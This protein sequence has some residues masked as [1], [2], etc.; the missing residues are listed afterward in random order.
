MGKILLINFQ[1][2]GNTIL[3]FPLLKALRRHNENDNIDMLVRDSVIQELLGP[4]NLV[5]HFFIYQRDVKGIK[6]F[7]S[8]ICVLQDLRRDLYDRIINFEQ[9]QT[10]KIMIF[11]AMM[12]AKEKI[13][14]N[15]HDKFFDP[16][17]RSITFSPQQQSESGLYRDIGK[18]LSCGDFHLPFPFF[19]PT[20]EEEERVTELIPDGSRTMI[21]I[22]PG[23]GE[24]LIYKRW[25]KERFAE[26][27]RRLVMERDASVLIFGGSTEV[28][29][30][31]YIVEKANTDHIYNMAGKFTVRETAAA[32]ARCSK[33]VSNDSGVMHLTAAMG[34][35]VIALFGPSSSIKNAPVGENHQ[36][37]CGKSCDAGSNE[38]CPECRQ[39]WKSELKTPRCL[40]NLKVET[41]L[42]VI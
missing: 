29:L 27:S 39:A 35:H 9:T 5:N 38:M 21:G 2:L 1:G 10:A 18:I 32:V 24:M 23:C 34:V 11:M 40:V 17:H 31:E 15:T 30:G 28:R 33:V 4:E 26:L 41:I 19:H 36:L 22:H 13:G 7:K 12:K 14:I 25:P 16:Y 20:K 8:R 42:D 37:L 3:L 6:L